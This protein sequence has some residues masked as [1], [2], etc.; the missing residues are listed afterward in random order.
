[1]LWDSSFHKIT[2]LDE[3]GLNYLES[4]MHL[5]LIFNHCYF[6]RPLGNYLS[7]PV[8]STGKLVT[9]AHSMKNN[10]NNKNQSFLFVFIIL[11]A[12]KTT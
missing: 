8:M 7:I 11:E 10:N 5:Y 3:G 2:F 9:I 1:M 12:T 6:L 4:V